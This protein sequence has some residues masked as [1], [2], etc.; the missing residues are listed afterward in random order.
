MQT[1][2]ALLNNSAARATPKEDG[3]SQD[4]PYYHPALQG[5]DGLTSQKKLGALDQ[6]KIARL[7]ERYGLHSVVRWKP[8]RVS[9]QF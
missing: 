2:L 1:S 4:E 9:Q 8:K 6:R 7:G 3:G 5:L